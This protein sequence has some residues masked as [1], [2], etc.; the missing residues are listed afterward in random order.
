[1]DWFGISLAARVFEFYQP[2][3]GLAR[4]GIRVRCGLYI[5]IGSEW[6]LWYLACEG[7]LLAIEQA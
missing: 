6:G 5:D 3:R 7:G 1:M 2:G 4:G